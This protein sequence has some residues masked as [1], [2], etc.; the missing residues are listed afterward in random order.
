MRVL[1]LLCLVLG[2]SFWAHAGVDGATLNEINLQFERS[3]SRSELRQHIDQFLAS[4]PFLAPDRMSPASA[5]PRRLAPEVF[6]L[7]FE[8]TLNYFPFTQLQKSGCQGFFC[9]EPLYTLLPDLRH[10]HLIYQWSRIERELTGENSSAD[11]D[12]LV[13]FAREKAPGYKAFHILQ[14]YAATGVDP[15][16]LGTQLERN[17][18]IWKA[19]RYSLNPEMEASPNRGYIIITGS[20]K[21][22]PEIGKWV[23]LFQWIESQKQQ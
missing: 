1:G 20:A 13:Q 19:V 11:H 4:T 21:D 18:K 2:L 17:D 5:L 7:L 10:R 22:F 14:S 9:S 23:A 12:P 16:R 6:D 8:I 3:G 15:R